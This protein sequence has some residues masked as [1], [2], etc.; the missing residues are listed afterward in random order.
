MDRRTLSRID[1][2]LNSE[3]VAELCFL[4]TDF[5]PRK[6]LE[7]I[8]SA[9]D[10]FLKLE[11]ATL[12][13][14]SYL[15]Q[16]FRTIHREDLVRQV[17]NG[18]RQAE[19]ADAVPSLSD[20]RVMLY[21]I[22]DD[23]TEE[24]LDKLK[25]LLNP[26]LN[27][28]PL[29]KS[30]TALDVFVEMEKSQLISKDDVSGLYKLL[31]EFDKKLAAVVEKYMQDHRGAL[32]DTSHY[33]KRPSIPSLESLS[34]SQPETWSETEDP[35]NGVR[36]DATPCPDPPTSP[37]E[38]EY[39]SFTHEPRGLCVIFNNKLFFPESN[40]GERGGT[41]KDEKSL[42]NLFH[43][44]GFE[45]VVH[46]NLTADLIESEITKLGQR[47]F[48]HDDALV[49]CVLSHGDNGCVYGIDG[50]KV[51]LRALTLPFTSSEVKGD[52]ELEADASSSTSNSVPN[53]ADFL[54]G[55]ATVAECKSFRNKYTGSIYIQELCRQLER[56]AESSKMEDIL[57]VLVHVNREVSKGVFLNKKQMPEPK[58]TLTK[59]VVL[60]Y[61]N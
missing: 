57:G 39:Y 40:L 23:M 18:S 19:E 31:L 17:Q 14:S 37:D 9:K 49:V 56:A 55:M 29:E 42:N 30:K 50:K 58:Y 48:S 1:D 38:E 45:V 7:G 6:R 10:L 8:S 36:S 26:K 46:N 4:C 52:A 32:T 11:D 43:R 2:E 51:Q 59:K 53:D 15:T 28:R 20:Y 12:L 34:V 33:Q 54:L 5:I 41:E 61:M 25:F 27:R 24:N 60:K 44:F 13:D 21:S 47:N 16:L 22:H 35:N 3:E